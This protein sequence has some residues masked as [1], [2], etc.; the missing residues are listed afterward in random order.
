MQELITKI[1]IFERASTCEH[2]MFPS[3][4]KSINSSALGCSNNT[5]KM[6]NLKNHKYYYGNVNA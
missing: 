6:S 5:K 1:Y 3:M 2:Y 4:I